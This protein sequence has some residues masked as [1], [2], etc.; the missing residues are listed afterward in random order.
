MPTFTALHR[1]IR[2]FQRL[3]L[4]ADTF[5]FVAG[6]GW[7]L[8]SAYLKQVALIC[9]KHPDGAIVGKYDIKVVVAE[10]YAQLI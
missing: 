6:E 7:I 3:R 4:Q 8:V 5:A 10:E 9:C 2:L 1:K